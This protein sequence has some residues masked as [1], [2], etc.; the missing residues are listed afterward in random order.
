MAWVAGAVAL[1]LVC[2]K[3]ALAQEETAPRPIIE[4][5]VVG[6]DAALPSL[7]AALGGG[8]LESF[9][10]RW[11]RSPRIDP[12]E[13]VDPGSSD[14]SVRCWIDLGDPRTARVYF[15]NASAERF[16]VRLVPLS[17]RLD[18]TDREVLSQVVELSVNALEAELRE[19]VPRATAFPPPE[20]PPVHAPTAPAP[21]PSRLVLRPGSFY[22][23]SAH[24]NQVAFTHGP[25][26]LVAL[27]WSR[28]GYGLSIGTRARYEL[29]TTYRDPRIGLRFATLAL[30]AEAEGFATGSAGHLGAK[31]GVGP[32]LVWLWPRSSQ[33]SEGWEPAEHR[34]SSALVVSAGVSG[35]LYVSARVSLFLEIGAEL[36]PAQVHYDIDLGSVN[37]PVIA[38]YRVR[39][40][41]AFGVRLW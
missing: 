17:G 25:G 3:A 31:L 20:P 21:I 41:G 34:L 37:E 28:P 36:D 15:T 40:T 11:R 5:V 27:V 8:A 35:G 32:D 26:L 10:I 1:G 19:G 33:A 7:E 29:P 6:S 22:S 18:E 16:V 14:V 23:L 38:R 9:E 2:A 12:V 39:P 4:V 13:L 24:S 30:R